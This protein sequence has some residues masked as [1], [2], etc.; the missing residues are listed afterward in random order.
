MNPEWMTLKEASCIV[1]AIATLERER[2]IKCVITFPALETV[3]TLEM[4]S[5]SR[6]G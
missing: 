5:F 2:L 6:L 1:S 4:D 3:P